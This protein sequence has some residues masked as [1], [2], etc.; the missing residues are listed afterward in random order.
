MKNKLTIKSISPAI[1]GWWAKFIEN[2]EAN[3][4]WYSPVAAWALCDIKYEKQEKI[5][6]QILPVLTTEFGM[7]PLH[8]NDGSCELLYLP[9]DKFIRSDESY[10]FSWHL[11]NSEGN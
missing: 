1:A 4:E 9:D 10:C 7:E 6:T 2:D 3:T 5:C 11:M 8:P